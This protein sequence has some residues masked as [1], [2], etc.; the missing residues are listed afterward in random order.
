MKKDEKEEGKMIEIIHSN[1]S[2]PKNYEKEYGLSV[3]HEAKNIQKTGVSPDGEVIFLEGTIKEKWIRIKHLAHS[4]GINLYAKSGYR[5]IFRQA[6]IIRKR[7]AYGESL[8]K[9]LSWI[10]APGYSEHHTGHA[11]DVG[12]TESYQTEK[13]FKETKAHK[14]LEEHKETF[15]ITKTYSKDSEVIVSEPWHWYIDEI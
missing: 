6:S 1:L 2:I 7:I 4:D 5:S 3:Q 11:V 8:D 15:G 14:W 12:S 10:A 9:V 13:L